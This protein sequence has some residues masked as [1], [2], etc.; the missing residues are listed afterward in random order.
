MPIPAIAAALSSIG[1]AAGGS[2]AAGG[3]IA[4]IVGEIGGLSAGAQGAVSSIQNLTSSLGGM[5]NP[6]AKLEGG[7][8][9]LY[10]A[11]N[12]LPSK[13][14]QVEH[15]ITSTAQHWVAALAAPIDTVKQLGDALSRFVQ[16]ANPGAVKMFTYHVENAFAT[17]GNILEPIFQALMRTAQRVGDTFAKLKPAFEPAVRAVEEIIDMVTTRFVDLAETFAPA[18]EMIGTAFLGFVT[19]LKTVQEP[20]TFLIRKFNEL[21]RMVY[22]FLG[23][24]TGFDEEGK[25][26]IA[27]R[28]PQY[29]STEDIQ[30][31]LARNSL[32]DSLGQGG[33]PKTTEG[34]LEIIIKK[35]DEL[36]SK[37]YWIGVIVDAIRYAKNELDPRPDVIPTQDEIGQFMDDPGGFL[38][39]KRDEAIAWMNRRRANFNLES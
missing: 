1:G 7:M 2:A 4:G 28:Q 19:I 17:I 16:F 23:I 35:L 18:I 5:Q 12:F 11:V 9:K 25:A 8:K 32:M 34:L 3:G 20:I 10:T 27:I 26:D 30:K 15:M 39:Q 29:S 38:S 33:Q 6:V 13:I 37:D 21:R 22:D 14:L 31:E 24:P 36:T